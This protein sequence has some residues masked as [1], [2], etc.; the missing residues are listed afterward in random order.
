[1]EKPRFAWK[2]NVLLALKISDFV[3]KGDVF[4][5]QEAVSI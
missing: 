2:R 3:W 1:M 4:V 5:V